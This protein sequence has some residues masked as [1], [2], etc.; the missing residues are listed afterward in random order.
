MA[1]KAVQ[2]VGDYDKR[3][4]GEYSKDESRKSG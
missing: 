3:Y 1:S 2:A 4:L